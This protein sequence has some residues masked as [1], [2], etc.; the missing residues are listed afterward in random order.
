MSS[1]LSPDNEQFI[2]QAVELG[3][4]HS[5]EEALDQAV[6]LLRKRAALLRHID[7]GTRQ[8]REGEYT[9]YDDEGLKEFFEEVKVQGRQR[10][11]AR[12]KGQ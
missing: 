12:K 11:E 3:T 6:E 10:Y 2:Q 4:F 7:E 8:L 1:G 5:R 9:D